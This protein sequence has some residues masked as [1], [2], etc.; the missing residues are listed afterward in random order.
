[1]EKSTQNFHNN[2]IPKEGCQFTCL[3]VFLIDFVFRTGKNYYP[4][5]FLGECKYDVKGKKISKYITD[6]IEISS[7][8]YRESSDEKN[9]DEKNSKEES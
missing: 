9:F 3:S 2:E 5:S 6:D 4:Q 7:D 8:F 1:M